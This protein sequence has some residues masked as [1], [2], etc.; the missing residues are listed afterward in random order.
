MSM[1]IWPFFAEKAGKSLLG[2]D[3]QQIR[4]LHR[5]YT[6][7]TI[8]FGQSAGQAKKVYMYVKISR[9]LYIQSSQ[10]INKVRTCCGE[11]GVSSALRQ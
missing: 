10:W 2:H 6:V 7:A 4:T 3:I 11:S 5:A 9:A 1:R 8:T